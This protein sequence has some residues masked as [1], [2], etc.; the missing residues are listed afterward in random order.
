MLGS[1]TDPRIIEEVISTNKI[2]VLVHAAAYKH[3]PIVENNII[4]GLRN[5]I[6]EY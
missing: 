5:N 2:E 1:V 4:E 3:V 6:L